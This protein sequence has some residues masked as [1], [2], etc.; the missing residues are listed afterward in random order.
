MEI[1]DEEVSL[2]YTRSQALISCRKNPND[3]P[4]LSIDN[5]EISILANSYVGILD[6]SSNFLKQFSEYSKTK[7]LDSVK[8]ELF[9]LSEV[10]EELKNNRILM[11]Y[12]ENIKEKFDNL[13]KLHRNFEEIT[14]DFY[15]TIK[16][17]IENF[18]INCSRCDNL[19]E[20]S[21][22]YKLKCGHILDKSCFEE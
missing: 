12:C 11:N 22:A 8:N 3:S 21:K 2:L 16:D 14:T 5:K 19:F 9:L 7:N 10:N 13:E 20:V 18:P 15:K 4:F 6:K 1:L 17:E